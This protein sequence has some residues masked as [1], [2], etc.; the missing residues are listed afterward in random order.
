MTMIDTKISEELSPCRACVWSAHEAMKL[1]ITMRQTGNVKGWVIYAIKLWTNNT[2]PETKKNTRTSKQN[3]CY[4]IVFQS[5]IQKN[6]DAF[7][8]G[9]GGPGVIK[10][11]N[12][13]PPLEVRPAVLSALQAGI[14]RWRPMWPHVPRRSLKRNFTPSGHPCLTKVSEKKMPRM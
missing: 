8:A 11:V 5:S 12:G 3:T 4:C 6:S 7:T 9:F 14:L 13:I 2:L 10:N 1:S